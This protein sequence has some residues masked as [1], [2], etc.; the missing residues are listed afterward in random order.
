ML[1]FVR[2]GDHAFL[3]FSL[4]LV[5]GIVKNA[6]NYYSH[7]GFHGSLKRGS[8]LFLSKHESSAS[9]I[10]CHFL[11]RIHGTGLFTYMNG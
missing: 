5:G 7:H 9:K 11:H 1:F 8:R 2:P 3:C 6:W 4:F 10:N